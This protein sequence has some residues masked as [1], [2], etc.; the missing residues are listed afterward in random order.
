MAQLSERNAGK[1]LDILD[2]VMIEGVASID[3]FSLLYIYGRERVGKAMWRDITERWQ[4]LSEEQGFEIA[5]ELLIGY[6]SG[7]HLVCFA[8]GQE[9]DPKT[10]A[11]QPFLRPSSSFLA[12]AEPDTEAA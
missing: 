4:R 1:V 10:K 11:G 7:Y 6:E 12:D 3:T 8:F 9:F 2:K 5:P